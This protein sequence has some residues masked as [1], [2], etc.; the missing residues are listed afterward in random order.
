M[1]SEVE[2]MVLQQTVSFLS[3][4]PGVRKWSAVRKDWFDDAIENSAAIDP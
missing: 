2:L 3:R 1:P 4:L